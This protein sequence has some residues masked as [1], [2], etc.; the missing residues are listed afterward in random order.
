[1]N[2]CEFGT[3]LAGA[4]P[5]SYPYRAGVQD[6]NYLGWREYGGARQR[7]GP[8]EVRKIQVDLFTRTEFD[9]ALEVIAA[10]LT[11]AGVA[12]QAPKTSYEPETGYIHHIL[13]CEVLDRT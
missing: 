4:D 1:M 2:L 13:L 12:F 10:A 6:G 5:T 3:L 9:P 11:A 8:L 7:S